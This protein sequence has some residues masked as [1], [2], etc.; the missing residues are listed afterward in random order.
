MVL[1]SLWGATGAALGALLGAVVG[2]AVCLRAYRARGVPP[3]KF[4]PRAADLRRVREVV[5]QAGRAARRGRQPARDAT[6]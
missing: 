1:I 6:G 4:V 5:G 3:A 2:V